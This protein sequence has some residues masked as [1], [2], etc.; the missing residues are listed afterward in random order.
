MWREGNIRLGDKIYWYEIKVYD[1]G[2]VYGINAGRISKLVVRYDGREV[3]AYDRGWDLDPV[4]ADAQAVVDQL[5]K[6]YQ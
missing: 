6:S 4:D 1:A 5:V 3:A 2:S